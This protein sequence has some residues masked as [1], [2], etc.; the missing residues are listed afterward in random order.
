MKIDEPKTPYVTDE[1]FN[2]LCA[3]DPD[4]QK[5]ILGKNIDI[6]SQE[7]HHDGSSNN[8]QMMDDVIKNNTMLNMN[9]VGS[10]PADYNSDDENKK[11]PGKKGFEYFDNDKLTMTNVK[12]P[13]QEITSLGGGFDIN[14]LAGKLGEIHDEEEE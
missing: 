1:E 6:N 12:P 3:E 8:D 11:S 4:Y 14:A 5:E 9:I 7:N 10:G 2:K 13:K